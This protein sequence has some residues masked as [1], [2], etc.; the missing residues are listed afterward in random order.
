MYICLVRLVCLVGSS[1]L[2]ATGYSIIRI[3]TKPRKRT[4]VGG[5][6]QEGWTINIIKA[7]RQKMDLYDDDW[8]VRASNQGRGQQHNRRESTGARRGTTNA[9]VSAKLETRKVEGEIKLVHTA[10]AAAATPVERSIPHPP[11]PFKNRE[12]RIASAVGR[13]AT[14]TF[15]HPRTSS[16]ASPSAPLPSSSSPS[17]SRP[18][19]APRAPPTCWIP[20]PARPPPSQ[21]GTRPLARRTRPRDAIRPHVLLFP[22]AELSLEDLGARIVESIPEISAICNKV[23]EGNDTPT[24]H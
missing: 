6:R 15:R 16:A 10:V 12:P 11:R 20:P 2:T 3:Q 14:S 9:R 8:Q 18:H 1:G 4:V 17:S 5:H 21:M 7:G 13:V 19:T 22:R 23:V 24:S